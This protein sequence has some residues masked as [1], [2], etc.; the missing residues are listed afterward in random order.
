MKQVYEKTKL[1]AMMFDWMVKKYNPVM[2][3]QLHDHNES[4]LEKF[5]GEQKQ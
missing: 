2:F 3:E 1:N 4:L 5:Q